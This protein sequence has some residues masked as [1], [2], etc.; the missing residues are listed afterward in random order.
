MIAE[1]SQPQVAGPSG[2]PEGQPLL[3]SRVLVHIGLRKAGNNW[4]RES[5]FGPEGNA[6]WVPGDPATPGRLRV[7]EFT[8]K[9]FIDEKGRL[10][11]DE[12]FDAAAL[13]EEL[14]PLVVPPGKCAT[15]VAARLGGHPLSNGFD[16]RQLCDR[17]KQVFPN[18]RIL[19][20]IREQR[21]MI[22]SSY[23][24]HLE[25]GGADSLRQYI[26]GEWESAQ[27]ALTS[28]FFKYDRLIRIYHSTFGPENVLTLPMEMI[29]AMPQT[30]I[31]RICAFA[32][33]AAPDD[34]PFHVKSNARTVYFPYL[35]LRRLVPFIRSSRG[36]AFS[37][38][39]FGRKL[40]RRVHMRLVDGMSMVTP[41]A[42][43]R[44]AKERLEK[45][46]EAITQ[47]T[48]VVSNRETE[49]LI[50]IDLGTFGYRV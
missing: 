37:P 34:V 20:L 22:L 23:I 46:V 3:S 4:L 43:D 1:K 10:L 32:D 29:G 35:A 13:R 12:D 47:D 2:H 14:A 27:P 16:R 44:R 40:G 33:V 8:R 38:S 11:P 41:R 21:S 49:K 48:Y 26:D 9:L 42:L 28:H 15:F 36:N 39:L 25:S 7:R 19:I 50:G 31:D 45:E 30:F 5:V 24:Q 6:F 17:I 18:A